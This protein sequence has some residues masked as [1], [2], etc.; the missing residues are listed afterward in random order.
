MFVGHFCPPG[1][2]SRTPLNPDTIRIRIHNTTAKSGKNGW[3][4]VDVF[5]THLYHI[6]MDTPCQR[7]QP[8]LST[9]WQRWL[10]QSGLAS[11]LLTKLWLEKDTRFSFLSSLNTQLVVTSVAD[12]DP[13]SGAFLTPG[14]QNHIFES[15]VT[16]FWIKSSIILWKLAQIFFFS[17]SKI[18]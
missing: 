11:D 10:R 8:G 1:S 17:I 2:G 15:F 9:N 3:W 12:P 5:A 18:K 16:T 4:S 6:G 7:N 14:S 13:G